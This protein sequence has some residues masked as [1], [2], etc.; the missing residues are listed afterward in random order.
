MENATLVIHP[1][2]VRTPISFR[3]VVVCSRRCN[4]TVRVANP[5]FRGK[6]M[7]SIHRKVVLPLLPS[8]TNFLL[9]PIAMDKKIVL[10]SGDRRAV[11]D[12]QAHDGGR[13]L[14]E[15][16]PRST[17]TSPPTPPMSNVPDE[18]LK[19][20]DADFVKVDQATLFHLVLVG[21]DR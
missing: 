6:P 8:A 15:R 12:D 18:E 19:A 3:G 21:Y 2:A 7:T 14:R 10:K 17:L 16:R 20:W 13:L 5:S 4:R 9:D 1:F 11:A